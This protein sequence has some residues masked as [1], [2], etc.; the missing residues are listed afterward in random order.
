MGYRTNQSKIASVQIPSAKSKR[1]LDITHLVITR[2]F[3]SF[4]QKVSKSTTQ[5]YS[6]QSHSGHCQRH[7]QTESHISHPRFEKAEADGKHHERDVHR[8]ESLIQQFG[9]LY[10]RC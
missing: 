6:H 10:R 3:P 1:S 7:E 4:I 2:S 5:L 8:E 9:L